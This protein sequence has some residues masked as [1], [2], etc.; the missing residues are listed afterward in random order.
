MLPEQSG[1]EL[2]QKERVYKAI[3]KHRLTDESP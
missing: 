3:N 2:S 1:R